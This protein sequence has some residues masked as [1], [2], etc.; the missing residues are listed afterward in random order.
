MISAPAR[1]SLIRE[2]QLSMHPYAIYHRTLMKGKTG[3]IKTNEERTH[4]YEH[5]INE[6]VN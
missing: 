5:K 6:G 2:R 4:N 1:E 3:N